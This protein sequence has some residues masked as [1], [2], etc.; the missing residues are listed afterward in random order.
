MKIGK[1]LVAAVVISVVNMILGMVTCGGIF[2]WVYKLEPINVWKPMQNGPGLTFI[3][4]EFILTVLFILV[5][6][7]LKN[8]IPAKSK[9][10]KGVVYGLF[11]WVA[12]VLPG[13]LATYSFMTV[14]TTVVVYWT[15]Q[16]L[17]FLPIKGILAATIYGD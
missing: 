13:M 6:V 14:A 5:Y 12:G 1:V 7:M 2:S 10:A 8:G 9:F 16:S 15:I 17:I 11:V 4:G 3:A